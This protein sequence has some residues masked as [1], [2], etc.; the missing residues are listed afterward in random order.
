MIADV[1]DNSLVDT[2]F[3]ITFEK[4]EKSASEKHYF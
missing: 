3:E 4:F 1:G 2:V